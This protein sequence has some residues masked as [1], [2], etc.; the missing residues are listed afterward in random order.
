MASPSVSFDLEDFANINE[1]SF[2][3]D[4]DSFTGQSPEPDNHPYKI[5]ST[6]EVAQHMNECI[7]EMTNILEVNI[8]QFTITNS[9]ILL[10]YYP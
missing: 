4:S 1:C 5:L 8:Y 6:E 10:S 2:D 9:F 7:K 3:D